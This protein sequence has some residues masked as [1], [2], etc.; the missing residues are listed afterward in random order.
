MEREKYN[1]LINFIGD[2]LKEIS[3]EMVGFRINR[4]ES[5]ETLENETVCVVIGMVGK[6]RGRI[7]LRTGIR[8]AQIMAEKINGEKLKDLAELYLCISEFTN[9]LCGNAV[10]YLNNRYRGTELRLTPPAVFE[11]QGVEITTPNIES[12]IIYFTSQNGSVTVDVG[13]EGVK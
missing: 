11:G 13:I 1:S 5:V 4:S 10:T 8:T 2:A 3:E 6:H 12:S 9:V 7:I